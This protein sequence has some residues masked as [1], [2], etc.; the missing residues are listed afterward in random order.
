MMDTPR[1]SSSQFFRPSVLAL[2]DMENGRSRKRMNGE[3][4]S[5]PASTD[6]PFL[7]FATAKKG[8]LACLQSS[9]LPIVDSSAHLEA[10]LPILTGKNGSVAPAIAP[11]VFRSP[12]QQNL[13]QDY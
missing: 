6:G 9:P 10:I 3:V 1:R 2:G 13:H 5:R 4:A 7:L 8:D 11:S 12:N